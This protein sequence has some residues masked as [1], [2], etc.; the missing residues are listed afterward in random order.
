M[1][2]KGDAM[3]CPQCQIVL[4]KKS[5]CDWMRCVMCK[6]EI[7]WATRGAR[8]GPGVMVLLFFF[9]KYGYALLYWLLQSETTISAAPRHVLVPFERC[10]HPRKYAQKASNIFS[11][12][13]LN[14]LLSSIKKAVFPKNVWMWH[15]LLTISL[16]GLLAYLFLMESS[17][18]VFVAKNDKFSQI[19]DIIQFSTKVLNGNSKFFLRYYIVLLIV[20]YTKSLFP[21]DGFVGVANFESK[22]Y[23]MHRQSIEEWLHF[24]NRFCFS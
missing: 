12:V 19:F 13:S 23:Q 10:G 1:I 18:S 7:C 15:L 20:F 9:S 11:V 24:S 2:R 21:I 17:S 3:K 5:G 8:W 6:T 4:Q 14:N 22:K 16:E